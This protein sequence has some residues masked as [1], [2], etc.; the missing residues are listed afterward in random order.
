[1]FQRSNTHHQD[2]VAGLSVPETAEAL[3]ISEK[4]VKREWVSARAWLRREL[5][6]RSE[7]DQA[8]QP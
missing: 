3:K 5:E 8:A 2:E 6:P 7:S 4:T 1:M